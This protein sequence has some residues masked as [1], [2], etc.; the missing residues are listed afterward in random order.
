MKRTAVNHRKERLVESRRTERIKIKE[1]VVSLA[2]KRKP[3]M[4]RPQPRKKREKRLG[5]N[6][7]KGKRRRKKQRQ[8]RLQS[9]VW[10]PITVPLLAI[11]VVRRDTRRKSVTTKTRNVR[12]ARRLD[13]QRSCARQRVEVPT[14]QGRHPPVAAKAIKV[15]ERAKAMVRRRILKTCLA[16]TF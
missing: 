1:A 2:R 7:R 16:G 6:L 15:K 11:A 8:E 5:P 14:D 10:P 9:E 3:R 13:I 12:Y 4:K